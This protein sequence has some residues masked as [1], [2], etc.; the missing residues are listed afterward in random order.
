VQRRSDAIVVEAREQEV[1]T[2][3]LGTGRRAPA[4]A[5]P[6]IDD[7]GEA[8]HLEAHDRATVPG[9]GL[10]YRVPIMSFRAPATTR[11]V[12]VPELA[13][14]VILES[15]QTNQARQ[16]ILAGP[17]DLVR[18]GGFAGRTS[19]LFVAPGERFALGWG[20]D[21]ALRVHRTLEHGKEERG[22]MSAWTTQARRVRVRISN[23]GAEARTI[24][25]TERVPVSEIE[26]LAIEVDGAA[27]TGQRKP[28]HDG[29]VR[30]TMD[31]P[32]F[33]HDAVVLRYLVKKH[34]DVVGI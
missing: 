33:G 20:P 12:L 8:L 9:D 31:L 16:P 22:I 15:T 21:G 7:G 13:Q 32:A 19:L 24:H 5:L 17:V 26:K 3:G 14:A 1:Q 4:P 10:P 27:T 28:D 30:W 18:D 34:G 6:G 2:T 29:L 25:I 23:L 11:H